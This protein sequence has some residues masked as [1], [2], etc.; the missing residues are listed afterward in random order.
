MNA[1]DYCCFLEEIDDLT[2]FVGSPYLFVTGEIFE[3]RQSWVANIPPNRHFKITSHSYTQI[4]VSWT[5]KKMVYRLSGLND[6]SKLVDLLKGEEVVVDLTSLPHHVWAP[7][8]RAALSGVDKV[9]ATYM[10]P[11]EYARSS[12][13]E[14]YDLS[15]KIEGIR[16]IPGFVSLQDRFE[17]NFS[18]VPFIGFERARF[19]FIMEQTQPVSSYTFPVVGVP[20]FKPEFPF[21]ALDA[22]SVVLLNSRLQSNIHFAA[23][24]DPFGAFRELSAIAQRFPGRFMKIAPIGTKPHALGAFLFALKSKKGVEF[25]YDHPVRKEKRSNGIGKMFLYDVSGFLK[26]VE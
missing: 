13:S 17:S 4:E 12:D 3:P 21:H 20:G 19:A 23:A 8:I 22:N 14:I 18:F 5:G 1:L 6:L 2:S 24:N 7:L 9:Y 10:E 26:Y 25:V 16:P 15:E 11:L